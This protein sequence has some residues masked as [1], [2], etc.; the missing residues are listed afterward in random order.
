MVILP[1]DHCLAAR[2]A[3]SPKDLVGE[4]FVTVSDFTGD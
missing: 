2:K 1:I 4:T 3:I